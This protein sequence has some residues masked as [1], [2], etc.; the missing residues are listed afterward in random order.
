MGHKALAPLGWMKYP[1][2]SRISWTRAS[3]FSVA[4]V[5]PVFSLITVVMVPLPLQPFWEEPL[6]PLWEKP[7]LSLLLLPPLPGLFFI[8]A[9]VCIAMPILSG[10]VSSSSSWL[11]LFCCWPVL[12]TNCL[13]GLLFWATMPITGLLDFFFD[14]DLVTGVDL[15]GVL[16]PKRSWL[17]LMLSEMSFT[18]CSTNELLLALLPRLPKR[19]GT[20][21][22]RAAA[23]VVHLPHHCQHDGCHSFCCCYYYY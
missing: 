11:S 12:Y 3:S 14:F 5:P 23:V 17:S 9:L 1:I 16:D 19:S 13:A 6:Q 10:P 21:G 2:I 8:V 20:A 18:T 4:L 22:W 7:L 15:T